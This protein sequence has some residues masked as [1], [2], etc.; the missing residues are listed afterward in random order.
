M[1]EG[2]YAD[3]ITRSFDL[4][5]VLSDVFISCQIGEVVGFLGRNGSGKSTLLK[6]IMGCI[7]ADHKF[8]KVGNKSIGSI[9]QAAGL[10]RYLPQDNFLP[11][12]IRIKDIISIFCAREQAEE[13]LQLDLVRPHKLKKSRQL[14]GG[15]RRIIEI[16]MMIYSEADYLMFDEPFNGLAPLHIEIIK[17]LIKENSHRKGF[18]ITDHDYRNVLDISTRV[19]LMHDGATKTIN[20]KTELIDWGYLTKNNL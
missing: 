13:L 7:K 10:I 2:L 20:N 8:V 14:S 3:S 1:K 4:R 9:Y 11:A 15:E 16:L 19:I 6:I 5:R 17:D 18:I 12:H